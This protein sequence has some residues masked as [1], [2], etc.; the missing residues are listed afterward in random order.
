M[1][2]TYART[3]GPCSDDLMFP[4]SDPLLRTRA[5]YEKRESTHSASHF[6]PKRLNSC[7]HSRSFR[8]TIGRVK[9]STDDLMISEA[10]GGVAGA[11]RG[12]HVRAG[13][14][15]DGDSPPHS[16]WSGSCP[17]P[18]HFQADFSGSLIART[19]T[20]LRIQCLSVCT[21]RLFSSDS[22]TFWLVG[23]RNNPSEYTDKR[24]QTRN[25]L[26]LL[27]PRI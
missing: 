25:F 19:Y 9:R 13:A 20:H 12:A 16:I 4:S 21:P 11:G 8:A 23:E 1:N 22:F 2:C 24:V 15:W 7:Y 6:S 26:G 17:K 14:L 5:D 10:T 3:A 18:T 27:R